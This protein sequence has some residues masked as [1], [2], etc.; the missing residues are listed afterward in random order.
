M[1]SQGGTLS[2]QFRS[3]QNQRTALLLSNGVVY[4]GFSSRGD[5]EPFHGWVLGYNATTLQQVLVYCTTANGDD[6]GV[7]MGGDG[8]AA[9]SAGSLYF[10][11]GDGLFDASSGGSDYGD[12]F[13][14]FE[15]RRHGPRLLLTQ[16]AGT[17]N[18]GNLD[19]GS[20]GAL[21]L[22]DQPG[23]HP[24]EM[25][26][27]G[28]NGTIYLVDRDNM[29]KFNSNKRPDRPVDPEHLAELTGGERGNFGVA[30]LL[31]R[32]RV[33]QPP[34]RHSASLPTHERP[35]PDKPTSQSPETY[36]GTTSNFDSRGGTMAI[37]ANGA[38]NGIVWALQSNGDSS[39]GHAPRLRREQPDA[40]VLHQRPG[41]HTRP[42]RPVAQIQRS[43]RSPTARR[44][45]STSQAAH[46]LR[47]AP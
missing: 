17:L 35:A 9:D 40:R 39:A 29:G 37:S 25:V 11:T 43:R 44:V 5:N 4:L 33:L 2:V 34:R 46:G 26:S 18:S 21:L 45:T 8:V 22:P 41:R 36:D 38:T 24:H 32:Q 3:A 14:R 6:G 42:A 13:V 27:A 7:W 28:K 23:S 1:G 30:R 47:P 20:G 12:S 15:P 10:I 19:L 16:G 31:Q